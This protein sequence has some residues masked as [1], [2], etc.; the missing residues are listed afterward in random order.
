MTYRD[1]TAPAGT[2]VGL[3]IS[4]PADG[5][6][7]LRRGPSAWALEA[8]A[9]E[10]GAAEVALDEDSAWRLFT[11]GLTRERAAAQATVSGDRWLRE[12]LLDAVAIIA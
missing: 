2:F 1:V 11:K 4:G 10:R 3:T 5:R 8:G 12:W 7:L 6:W 9:G